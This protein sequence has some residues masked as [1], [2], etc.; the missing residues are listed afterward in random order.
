MIW[1][2]RADGTKVLTAGIASYSIFAEMN[3]CFLSKLFTIRILDR[4][5]NLPLLNFHHIS[6]G[7]FNKIKSLQKLLKLLAIF[8]CWFFFFKFRNFFF[9]NRQIIFFIFFLKRNSLIWCYEVLSF[10]YW[11]WRFSGIFI[12]FTCFFGYFLRAIWRSVNA[13]NSLFFIIF[14]LSLHNRLTKVFFLISH[15]NLFR[16]FRYHYFKHST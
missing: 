7:A 8:L 16:K 6:T 12:F 5:I 13:F 4:S 14:S 9:L 10:I 3:K 15:I 1:W 11:Q 2:N